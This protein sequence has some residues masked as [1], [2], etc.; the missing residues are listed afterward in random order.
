VAH[1][2]IPLP[3]CDF[4]PSEVAVSWKVLTVLGHRVSF[5]TPT[6][7]PAAGDELMLTGE[8]LDPW[9]FVPLAR[10]LVVV[11]RPLRADRV[12]REDYADMAR[13]SEFNTP[14]SWDDI[15]L[16]SVDGL[17][18][19]G[20]HQARGMRPYLES[21]R[22]Q[23]VVVE[24]FHRDMP[25]GAICHGVLLAARSI[26]PATGR[27]ILWGRRTTSLTWAL[28]R[29]AWRITRVTRFWNPDYY[30]T[31]QEQPGQTVGYMSVEAEVTRALAR[32][33][34]YCDVDPTQPD[35]S[36]KVSGRARD[37]LG[38][39]RPAFVV[40]DGRY[41]SARWPGDVHTFASRFAQLLAAG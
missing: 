9:G 23:S 13:S 40:V 20:G 3:Q 7:R 33:E 8:G 36:V 38:D 39:D 30:R 14:M 31:Y 41:V 29:T 27:S 1:V 37:R 34:D 21:S 12:A 6:G 4:D 24:A 16:G 10:R 25:V 18:L 2:L 17:L 26:D 19:P 15:D 28:E 35:A 5:A 22:L 32:P 11:G